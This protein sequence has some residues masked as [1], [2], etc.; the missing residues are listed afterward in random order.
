MNHQSS[1][2]ENPSNLPS[3]GDVF[4]SVLDAMSVS[5]LKDALNHTLE[6]LTEENY[7]PALIEAYLNAL[8]RKSPMPEMP[9]AKTSYARFQKKLRCFA[10]EVRSASHR[11]R[12]AGRAVM[13]ACLTI[14]SV[15]GMMV[16]A[17]AA[18]ID[19]F[20]TVAQWTNAVF[21]L[22]TVRS[23]G[24]G[25]VLPEETREYSTLQEAL[26]AYQ[27]TEV[28]APTWVPDGY[29]LESIG[30]EYWEDIGELSFHC[31]YANESETLMILIKNYQSEPNM[32]VEKMDT[33]VKTVDADG[34]MIYLL[35]NSNNCTASWATEHFEYAISGILEETEL[36]KIALSACSTIK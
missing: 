4:T 16:V 23:N 22:G 17:Q 19:V 13:A 18:G 12:R 33:P 32:Q 25:Y 11:L 5:E 8:D 28:S 31:K 2:R 34:T 27:V 15:L 6:E 24:I 3:G 30:T 14:I 36:T 20:G 1:K 29:V 35:R 9:D 26:D 10:P 21:S 7:D